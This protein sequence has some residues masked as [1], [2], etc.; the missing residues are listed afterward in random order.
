MKCCGRALKHSSWVLLMMLLGGLGPVVTTARAGT[1]I[2][3]H[4]THA[5]HVNFVGTAGS[6]RRGS[7]LGDACAVDNFDSAPLNDL[8]AGATIRTAHLYWAGS[9]SNQ[10]GSNQTSP[11][12]NITFEGQSLTADRQFTETFSLG[13]NSYDFFSGEKDVTAIVTAKGNGLYTFG[14]LDVN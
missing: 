4:E 6:L 5:G 11:D 12:W 8:P 2:G 10:S 14:N 13:S 1:A 9:Y 3:L 7:N